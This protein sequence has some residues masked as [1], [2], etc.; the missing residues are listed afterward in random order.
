MVSPQTSGRVHV[1]REF[2]QGDFADVALIDH[3]FVNAV[4]G[5]VLH[6]SRVTGLSA[7]ASRVGAPFA[8]AG[9]H[10]RR[11]MQA[12]QIVFAQTAQ[13]F[14]RI[15][16]I[17]TVDSVEDIQLPSKP[18]A[19]RTCKS[20]FAATALPVEVDVHQVIDVEMDFQ[21]EP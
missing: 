21:P 12:S 3:E 9:E 19:R 7:A 14:H 20:E 17:V 4:L 13:A 10:V 15:G 8:S 2:G 11:H 6:Q 1:L 18:K 16:A 5:R